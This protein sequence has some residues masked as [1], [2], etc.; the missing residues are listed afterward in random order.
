MD[1]TENKPD[2]EI[3]FEIQSNI[4]LFRRKWAEFCKY[5]ETCAEKL[6]KYQKDQVGKALKA[7]DALDT[8]VVSEKQAAYKER[9]VSLRL[10]LRS[11]HP[12]IVVKGRLDSTQE[13]PLDVIGDKLGFLQSLLIKEMYNQQDKLRGKGWIN[14][15][16]SS[17]RWLDLRIKEFELCEP[18]SFYTP[19]NM[20]N[21]LLWMEG[22][23]QNREPNDYE[24]LL[25]SYALLSIFHDERENIPALD[26]RI[27]QHVQYQGKHFKR[28]DFCKHLES[29][30]LTKE[31]GK[32]ALLDAW[33]R[34]KTHLLKPKQAKAEKPEGTE[35]KTTDAK[36]GGI[37]AWLK[38]HPH[39]YSLTAGSIFL[40]LFFIFG[41]LKVQ[42]R[43]W[44]WGT[45]ALSFLVLILSLLGGRSSR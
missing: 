16:H 44:C 8:K 7:L 35:Q 1:T 39:S 14:W 43:T 6:Y 42:W 36:C 32:A 38:R 21:P 2:S 4:E 25:C 12:Q 28:D 27:Y 29:E 13:T 17:T 24:R 18:L 23:T 33:Q 34:V 10:K 45:A 30:V 40:I 11:C 15:E 3:L 41:L 22:Y 31:G 19:K 37:G 5:I 20:V 9:M 26:K